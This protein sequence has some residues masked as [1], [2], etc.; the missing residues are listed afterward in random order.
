MDRLSNVIG[1]A[2]ELTNMMK[3]VPRLEVKTGDIDQMV[4]DMQKKFEILDNR[5]EGTK[6]V[7][8]KK[9]LIRAIPF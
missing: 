4:K 5:V 6:N 1:N 9:L 7:L 8:K 2:K 3:R